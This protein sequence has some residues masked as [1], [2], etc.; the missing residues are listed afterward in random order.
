VRSFESV[1]KRR[2]RGSGDPPR[3]RTGRCRKTSAR[4]RATGDGGRA[5]SRHQRAST[6]C[7]ALNQ[8]WRIVVSDRSS[9]PQVRALQSPFPGAH[10]RSWRRLL[11]GDPREGLSWSSI[12]MNRST[13]WCSSCS[14]RRCD[15]DVDRDQAD[16]VP[17]LGGQSPIV[18]GAHRKRRKPAKSVTALVELKARFDE[19]ANIRWARDLERAGVQV[20]FGFI[21]LKTH[22][23]AVARGAPRGAASCAT[24]VHVATG[25]YHPITARIYTDLSYFTDD[26]AIARDAGRRYSTSSPATP[27]L[28][29]SD[30]TGG[31][32]GVTLRKRHGRD[33]SM[34][35]SSISQGWAARGRSG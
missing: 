17:D 25:N 34:P 7:L 32:A 8:T 22:G 5:K 4:F 2:R 30:A 14:R 27:S 13:S 21:E 9:R 20:V 1:L 31:V 26:P 19:E 23:E 28:P 3:T 10:S 12:P 18:Q 11:R 29:H 6:A 15:P 24:Y 35:R 16:A 33:T